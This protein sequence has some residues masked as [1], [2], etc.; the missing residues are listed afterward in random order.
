MVSGV[1]SGGKTAKNWIWYVINYAKNLVWLMN[2]NFA[3]NQE[4]AA[5]YH[6]QFKCYFC[7][8][9]K[10]IMYIL[11]A[12]WRFDFNRLCEYK[13]TWNPIFKFT[14]LNFTLISYSPMIMMI[15]SMCEKCYIK[16]DQSFPYQSCSTPPV[17]GTTPIQEIWNDR[18][19]MINI[20]IM[21]VL[22]F[23]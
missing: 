10:L 11:I 3:T 6:P 9:N 12:P 7:D 17:K 15:S 19:I 22:I 2:C 20:I 5:S 23:Y 14:L 4:K 21:I 18:L 13:N 1:I 16:F 8:S